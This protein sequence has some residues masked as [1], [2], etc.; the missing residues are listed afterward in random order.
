MPRPY[1]AAARPAVIPPESACGLA[2]PSRLGRQHL[3]PGERA[4]PVAPWWATPD[5]VKGARWRSRRF[6]MAPAPLTRSGVPG[7]VEAPTSQAHTRRYGHERRH[8]RLQEPGVRAGQ[9]TPGGL[10]E[11]PAMTALVV[12]ALAAVARPLH[13]VE[14][15]CTWVGYR[16]HPH[17]RVCPSCQAPAVTLKP[18]WLAGC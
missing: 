1:R 9:R 12:Q 18:V 4:C 17:S 11:D 7:R 5:R 3:A 14:C 6:A 2:Y 13:R 15:A 8:R 10:D 16:R